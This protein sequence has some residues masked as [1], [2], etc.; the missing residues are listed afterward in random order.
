MLLV[1]NFCEIVYA[2][3]IFNLT[4]K[5]FTLFC[6]LCQRSVFL[7]NIAFK[8]PGE[9]YGLEPPAVDRFPFGGPFGWQGVGACHGAF[10]RT[11]VPFLRNVVF[12]VVPG[13][14]ELPTSTLSV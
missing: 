3:K 10:P 4:R 11:G 7:K 1:C 2:I 8:K 5:K 13:R 14:V 12:L 6:S 9:G